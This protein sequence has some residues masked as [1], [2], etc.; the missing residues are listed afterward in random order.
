MRDERDV[1][2][3]RLEGNGKI[4]WVRRKRTTGD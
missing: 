3:A 1:V 2:V 4:S